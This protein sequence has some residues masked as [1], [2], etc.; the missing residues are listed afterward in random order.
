LPKKKPSQRKQPL[1]T[2]LVSV[3]EALDKSYANAQIFARTGAKSSRVTV[4]QRIMVVEELLLK[5]VIRRDILRYGSEVW[6]VGE[7][8]MEG[9]ITR[10]YK[11]WEEKGKSEA[12]HNYA[13]AIERRE[14]Q[15][16]EAV[17]AKS[18]KDALAVL[19]SI[20][21]IKGIF[22]ERVDHSGKMEIDYGETEKEREELYKIALERH[23]N[24]KKKT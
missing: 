3:N 9:Y 11:K 7:R 2:P 19:N 23:K 16:Q 15:L 10:I 21:K 4:D 13:I 8:Q 24:D 1:S 20:D 14:Y 22:I 12:P 18:V 6:K 5:G 17:K